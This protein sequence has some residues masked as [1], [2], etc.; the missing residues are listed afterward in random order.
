M[1]RGLVLRPSSGGSVRCK[2]RRTCN[3]TRRADLHQS[4]P[5]QRWSPHST[6]SHFVRPGCVRVSTLAAPAVRVRR[7][8]FWGAQLVCARPRPLAPPWMPRVDS[9]D[10]RRNQRE[11]NRADA[12][13]DG[14]RRNAGAS[15]VR[16][17]L[18]H[19]T[20]APA[21]LDNLQ[22]PT[23]QQGAITTDRSGPC[24]YLAAW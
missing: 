8:I 9:S 11:D 18:V 10:P 14:G 12:R 15:P 1:L 13:A 24:A 4:T 16:A 6:P 2:G 17:F 5:L 20:I 23:A 7:G 19:C 21:I 3:A 22:G